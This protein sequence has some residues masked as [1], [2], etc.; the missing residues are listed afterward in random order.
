MRFLELRNHVS[1]ILAN[2]EE[3]SHGFR[4]DLLAV[5]RVLRG[6]N[7]VRH[8]DGLVRDGLEAIQDSLG[9]VEALLLFL[10]LDLVLVVIHDVLDVL[11]SGVNASHHL[12]ETVLTTLNRLVESV[13][14]DLLV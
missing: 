8:L 3:T 12:V 7:L 9:D 2:G 14:N 4:D 6:L 5:T 13:S 1:R 10:G 11:S